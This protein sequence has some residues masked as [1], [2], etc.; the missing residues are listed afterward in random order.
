MFVTLPHELHRKR[1]AALSPY[2]SAANVRQLEPLLQDCL[3]KLLERLDSCRKSGQVLPMTLA[4]KALTSDI[5]TSYAFGKSADN[6]LKEDFN[7]PFLETVQSFFEVFHSLV[8][9]AWLGPLIGALPIPILIN[10]LPQM[11]YME[12]LKQVGSIRHICL[13][14]LAN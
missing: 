4:Y 11:A 3:S 12:N 6:L 13:P 9:I 7:S 14:Y 5:I 10:L 1:R 8:H 2:F